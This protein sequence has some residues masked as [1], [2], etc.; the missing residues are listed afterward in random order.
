MHCLVLSIKRSRVQKSFVSFNSI[1]SASNIFIK[2]VFADV[3]TVINAWENMLRNCVEH[4]IH[5]WTSWSV[6]DISHESVKEYLN[7]RR[8][9]RRIW[10]IKRFSYF[11]KA[12]KIYCLVWVRYEFHKEEQTH[13]GILP[14]S[15]FFL[16]VGHHY[17]N[18]LINH[19]Q[20]NSNSH[21]KEH[22]GGVW[23]CQIWSSL[24]TW[25]TSSVAIQNH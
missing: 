15:T 10:Q 3:A 8:S 20:G 1:S 17:I 6:L 2:W 12:F 19:W 23:S 9:Q 18:C 14:T 21:E 24:S 4:D 16:N 5:V 7:R 11:I 25:I 22:A 13:L